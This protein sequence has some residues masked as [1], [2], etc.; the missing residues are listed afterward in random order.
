MSVRLER[1]DGT[2]VEQGNLLASEIGRSS[3]ATLRFGAAR[4]LREGQG[5]RLTLT[6]LPDTVYQA[7]AI[8]K[9]TAYGFTPP[10]YFGDGHAEYTSGTEWRGFDQP[11][12]R[13]DTREGDLQFYLE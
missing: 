12:G 3:W 13:K 10:T 5:Y 2:L 11:G 6:A 4:V 8:R 1:A 9:G 7:V